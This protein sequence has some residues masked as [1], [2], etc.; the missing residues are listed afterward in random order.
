MLVRRDLRVRYKN[1]VLGFLWSLVPLLL[2]TFVISV[3][4]KRIYDVGP[5]D[6]TAYILCAY[7]PWSF[8]QVGLLDGTS[9]VL[10]QYPLLKKVY[11]PREVLPIAAVA[12]Q[13][14]P[15]AAGDRRLLRLP[16]RVH[17]A[18]SS[19]GRGRRRLA[20]LC[21]PAAGRDRLLSGAGHH[22]LHGGLERVP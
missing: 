9:S 3:V 11:F 22:L 16:V 1:S 14:R 6:L 18:A 13:R 12:R 7:I 2:Q 15:S 21:L 8:I 10:A 20:I 19:A 4:V 17:A 5:R